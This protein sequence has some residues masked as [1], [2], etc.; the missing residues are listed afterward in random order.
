MV[1]LG[2][3]AAV[4]IGLVLG[5]L[6]GWRAG[7]WAGEDRRL[8][9][10]LATGALTLGMLLDLAGLMTGRMWLAY[11]GVALMAG[12]LGGLKYGAMPDTRFWKSGSGRTRER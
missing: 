6:I 11:G 4:T 12:L 2:D 7:V 3:I 9:W 1:L 10:A 8:F 5:G